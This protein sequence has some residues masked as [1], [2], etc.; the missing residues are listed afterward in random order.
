VS[1]AKSKRYFHAG[2]ESSSNSIV[3]YIISITDVD[4][5]EYDL[6]FERLINPLKASPP[7]FDIYF[8]W[9]GR[10]GVTNYVFKRFK[11]TA[12]LATYNTFRYKAVILELGKVF[13]L[14]KEEID[15]LSK[16]SK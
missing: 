3:H 7:D 2:T 10:N 5:V 14:P 8:S 1:Y 9:E 13:G 15:K 12:L 16:T 6:Y 11:N 4:F